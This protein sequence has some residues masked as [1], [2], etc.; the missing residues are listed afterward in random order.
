M[1]FD[2]FVEVH[3]RVLF[4]YGYVV[5]IALGIKLKIQDMK[6]SVGMRMWFKDFFAVHFMKLS[7]C[8]RIVLIK[9]KNSS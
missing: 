8:W 2:E 1:Y 5:L 7:G 9:G 6:S 3:V 4:M